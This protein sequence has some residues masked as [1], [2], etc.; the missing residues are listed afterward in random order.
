MNHYDQNNGSW[1]PK[2]DR[3][4]LDRVLTNWYSADAAGKR[5]IIARAIL[6]GAIAIA[7]FFLTIR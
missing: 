3:E 4:A 5:F 1:M 7:L 6:I 2:H